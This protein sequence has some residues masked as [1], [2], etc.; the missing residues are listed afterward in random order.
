MVKPSLTAVIRRLGHRPHF[1]NPAASMKKNGLL[2]GHR[3]DWLDETPASTA[4]T[5][6]IVG[7]DDDIFAPMNAQRGGGHGPLPLEPITSRPWS[8]LGETWSGRLSLQCFF[9]DAGLG[10]MAS[11]R[12]PDPPERIGV[13]PDNERRRFRELL[14]VALNRVSVLENMVT[15][16]S[17]DLTLCRA[18]IADLCNK[19]NQQAAELRAAQN[20]SER[21]TESVAA[22]Q[23]TAIEQESE[24][25]AAM[26]KLGLSDND[27]LALQ[28]Q[29]DDALNHSAELSQRL[30]EANMLLNDKETAVA[31]TQEQFDRLNEAFAETQA[32]KGELAG[33]IEELKHRHRDELNDQRERFEALLGRMKIVVAKRDQE[34]KRLEKARANLAGQYNGV[35]KSV[36]VLKSAQD[37]L[38]AKIDSR[39]GLIGLLE[40]QLRA[41]RETAERRIDELNAELRRVRAEHADAEHALEEIC[42]DITL[43]L[44][45]FAVRR[46]RTGKPRLE[47]ATPQMKAA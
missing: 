34:I 17:A 24:A 20:E 33:L 46:A 2:P 30:L 31:S 13:L 43:L 32:E 19:C 40:S 9:H 29:L 47:V 41:E 23:Q 21:L 39:T 6:D 26:H 3:P 25:A 7:L 14:T 5:K 8:P 45:E 4:L 11:S 16:Q 15:E 36:E 12:K 37:Q 44:P 35:V 1:H 18:Q 27:R 42:K 38:Q 28:A 22:L 10:T